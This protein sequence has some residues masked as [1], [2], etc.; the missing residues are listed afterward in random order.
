MRLFFGR[1]KRHFENSTQQD[2]PEEIVESEQLGTL[3]FFSGGGEPNYY[4]FLSLLNE[5]TGP[6]LA[7]KV[8]YGSFFGY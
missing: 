7:T 8:V 4:Y 5:S 2:A 1:V 3:T 6:F